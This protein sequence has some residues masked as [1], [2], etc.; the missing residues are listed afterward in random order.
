MANHLTDGEKEVCL[1]SEQH[2]WRP[3]VVCVCEYLF[4]NNIEDY[5]RAECLGLASKR[6][7]YPKCKVLRYTLF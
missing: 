6:D 2:V 3:S 1:Q 7:L 5:F 4:M